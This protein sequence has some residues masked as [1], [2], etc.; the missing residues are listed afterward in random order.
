MRK[1]GWNP[2]RRNKNI[3]IKKQGFSQNNKFVIPDRYENGEWVSFNENLIDPVIVPLNIN[4]Y[5]LILIIEPVYESYIYSCTPQDIIKIM[6]LFPVQHFEETDLKILIMRQPKS[7]DEIVSPVWGR[8][9]YYQSFGQYAG[10]AI[11]LEA[12]KVG[13]ALKWGKKLSVFSMKE[14]E[15]LRN[16]GH[17]VEAFKRYFLIQT[18][19]ESIRNTQ[20]FRTIP[21][22]MGHA[23][24]YYLNSM[25]PSM[26]AWDR[27]DDAEGEYISEAFHSKPQLD[28]EEAAN[29]YAKEFYEKYS[30]SGELPF[31]QIYDE[32]S[33]RDMGL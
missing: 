23:Y 26:E 24:D 16:D 13:L 7:K 4:G 3:G 28:K 15:M 19:P 27:D 18:T 14:L 10:T 5:E 25:K 22:E 29:R 32:S 17:Q 11:T 1:S 2:T 20:L 21:H 9:S 12:M 33:I 31:G 6:N 8:F 30:I